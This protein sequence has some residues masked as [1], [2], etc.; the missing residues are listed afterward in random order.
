LAGWCDA[1]TARRTGETTGVSDGLQLALPLP[2]FLED[3]AGRIV[4]VKDFS[5]RSPARLPAG[6]F[7]TVLAGEAGRSCR[8]E[9]SADLAAWQS[10]ALLTN[11]P[12]AAVFQDAAAAALSRGFCRA[13]AEE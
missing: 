10:L 4:V 3:L 6:Q 8:I 11:L 1:Q 5:L 12:A 7:Q 13:K 2:E 9:A